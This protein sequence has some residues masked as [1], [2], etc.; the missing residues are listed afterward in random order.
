MKSTGA[1]DRCGAPI[2]WVVMRGGERVDVDAAPVLAAEHTGTAIVATTQ[3][4]GD[5]TDGQTL[6]E[7]AGGGDRAL[8]VFLPHRVTC[9]FGDRQPGARRTAG[10]MGV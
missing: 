5:M 9:P 10:T 2:E 7:A 8:G 1:C 3:E 4:S 6:R